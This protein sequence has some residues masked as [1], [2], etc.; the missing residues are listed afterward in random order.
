[1]KKITVGIIGGTGKMGRFFRKFFEMNNCRV[2]VSSGSTKLKPGDCAKKSDV[3]MI[4]V[5]MDAAV[6]IIKKVSHYVNKDSLLIDTTS[7]KAA[8]VKAMLR[9]SKCEVIGM[10]PLFGPNVSSL[11][12]QT[13]VLCPAR[14][15][16]W[17]KW[18][19][20]IFEK[21]GAVIKISTPDKHDKM[22]S[23]IQGLNHFSTLAA[24][25]AMKQAGI[26]I[27]ESLEFASPVYKLRMM[28]IGRILS[29]DPELYA[30][31]GIMNSNNKKMLD[32]LE[33]S[34][35][36]L[37]RIIETKDR[38]EF[39]KYFDECAEFFGNFRKK[40]EKTSDYLIEKMVE[41]E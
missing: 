32:M 36:E 31:I 21:N 17:L 28:M 7:I 4:S 22:M 12:S 5:P 40:A 23:L 19:V 25:H 33:N 34:S 15:K 13:I 8:P 18:L 6:E 1:M 39:I 3:V 38:K 26:K 11:K 30:D 35:K 10:H 27:S 16:K 41:M 37:K 24:A 14:A 9:Y 29:Q 2:L 20:D